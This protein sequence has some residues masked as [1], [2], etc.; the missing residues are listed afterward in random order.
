MNQNDGNKIYRK[1]V[2]DETTSDGVKLIDANG[3]GQF[4]PDNKYYMYQN[5]NDGGKVYKKLMTDA[6]A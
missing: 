4:T 2:S 1:L 3:W 5:Q 6:T